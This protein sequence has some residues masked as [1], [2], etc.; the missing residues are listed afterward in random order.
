MRLLYGRNCTSCTLCKINLVVFHA[1]GEK[2]GDIFDSIIL[3]ARNLTRILIHILILHR[4][5]KHFEFGGQSAAAAL[6]S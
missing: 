5:W 2:E 6:Q 4:R 1:H 3:T